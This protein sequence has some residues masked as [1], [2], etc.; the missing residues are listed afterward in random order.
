MALTPTQL[1][2]LQTIVLDLGDNF[3]SSDD[4]LWESAIRI[5]KAGLGPVTGPGGQPAFD[6]TVADIVLTAEQI[7]TVQGRQGGPG[8]SLEQ[9]T[10]SVVPVEDNLPSGTVGGVI[11]LLTAPNTYAFTDV[12]TLLPAGPNSVILAEVGT[13]VARTVPAASGGFEVNNL[14]TGAGFERVLTTSDAGSTIDIEDEGVAV[15]PAATTL[16]FVGAGVTAAGGGTTK[17]ITIPG[18]AD[19]LTLGRAILTDANA[20][21]L[22]DTLVALNVGAADPTTS[23]HIEVGPTEIQSKSNGT[24]AAALD[25]NPLGGNTNVGA[26]SG[27]GLV[28]LFFNGNNILETQ[29]GGIR[30]YDDTGANPRIDLYND[31]A[32]LLGRIQVGVSNFEITSEVNGLPIRLQGDDLGG[33]LRFLVVGDPDDSVDLYFTGDVKLETTAAGID[34]TGNTGGGAG[35]V[36]NVNMQLRDTTAAVMGR[37]GFVSA[38]TDAFII[39]SLNHGRQVAIR[40]ED[41]AGTLQNLFIGNPDGTLTLYED[42]GDRLLLGANI[43]VARKDDDVEATNMTYQVQQDDGTVRMEWGSISSVMAIVNRIHGAE[44]LIQGEDAGGVLQTMI[45]IDPDNR[46]DLFYNGTRRAGTQQLGIFD[47]YADGNTTTENCRIDLNQADFTNRALLGF[48]TTDE[49][50]IRNQMHGGNVALQAEDAGGTIRNIIV[51]DPDSFTEIQ[52]HTSNEVAMRTTTA[53][54]GGI[55]ANN[56]ATGGGLERVLT[57]GDLPQL[58]F[59]DAD[60]SSANATLAD[61][62]DLSG[63]SMVADTVYAIEGYLVMS[64]STGGYDFNIQ[65]DNAP[66]ESRFILSSSDSQFL[67]FEFNTEQTVSAGLLSETGV[68]FYGFVHAHAT[69]ASTMDLQFAKNTAVG[70]NTITHLGS[71]V[72]VTLL[73]VA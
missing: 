47:I 53:A 52:D 25:L 21:D 55:T 36:Q 23:Q 4:R 38:V 33:T 49:L 12:I 59:M 17:T 56:Q 14:S 70:G 54:L 29:V 40:A 46:V 61:I 57:V 7:A 16:N 48:L 10:F 45:D 15:P 6:A 9:A 51:G 18:T 66:Q 73:G 24:T 13:D 58:Q 30:V 31:A 65:F 8:N 27:S 26:Q 72:R 41:A 39:D 19:P 1:S 42:G 71:W 3:P 44:T 37:I 68:W 28:T 50:L 22:T 43:I 32:T 35:S 62:T 5:Q 69:L 67:N 2:E 11:Y 60:Q 64:A 34:L 63:F 20:V